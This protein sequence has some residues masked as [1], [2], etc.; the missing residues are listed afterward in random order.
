MRNNR[1]QQRQRT[2]TFPR[3][4]YERADP[5]ICDNVGA[6]WMNMRDDDDEGLHR[7]TFRLR[8]RRDRVD[9]GGWI[10]HSVRVRG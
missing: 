7:Y 5:P 9:E 8:I 10:D 1:Q 4:T 3:K 2:L 6:K